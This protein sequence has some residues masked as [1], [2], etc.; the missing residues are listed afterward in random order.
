MS[1]SQLIASPPETCGWVPWL[2]AGISTASLLVIDVPMGVWAVQTAVAFGLSWAAVRVCMPLLPP[3]A[4]AAPGRQARKPA[5]RRE[6]LRRDEDRIGHKA[7][8]IVARARRMPPPPPEVRTETVVLR[9]TPAVEGGLNTL[10][11]AQADRQKAL[12][13]EV[14]LLAE[15]RRTVRRAVDV[16]GAEIDG[17]WHSTER[18]NETMIALLGFEETDGLREEELR[19]LRRELE[20]IRREAHRQHR[21]AASPPFTA[22]TARTLEAARTALRGWLLDSTDAALA[23]LARRERD[24]LKMAKNQRE[25]V[26][27]LEAVRSG[28]LD[29]GMRLVSGAPSASGGAAA[30]SGSSDVLDTL[31]TG[32][33]AVDDEE[34][35][36]DEPIVVDDDVAT[37]DA[38]V[39]HLAPVLRLILPKIGA[40]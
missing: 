34:F 37:D 14:R 16:V 24:L 33:A 32:L 26:K 21:R 20:G 7:M 23:H 27:Q 31:F 15:V 35:R 12:R 9:A 38:D 1:S 5:E 39:Q 3:E 30:E 4:M 11:A 13:R 28:L 10:L 36:E 29:P 25:L 40:A 17:D 8:S 22:D 6:V 18:A 2:A 19:E